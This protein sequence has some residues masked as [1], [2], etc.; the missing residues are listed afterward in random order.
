MRILLADDSTTMR[1]II[2]RVLTAVGFGDDVTEAVDGN[3][4]VFLFKS[5]EFDLVISDWNMP[6]KTGLEVVQEIRVQDDDV[7]VIFVITEAEKGRVIK[8]LELSVYDYLVK[9][10]TA[11]MLR[12]KIEKHCFSG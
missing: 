1:K 2:L 6:G 3:E 7:P 10:F 12:V 4:V 11:E 8:A 5:G 9:P